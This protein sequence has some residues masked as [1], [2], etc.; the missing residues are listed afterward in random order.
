ML[1]AGCSSSTGNGS[2]TPTGT[3]AS[4]GSPQPALT[5]DLQAP[6]PSRARERG[7]HPVVYVTFDDGPSSTNTPPLLTILRR[8]HAHATFFVI[9]RFARANPSLVKAEIAAGH[10]VGGHSWSHPH[11]T[12]LSSSKVRAQLVSTRDLL[13]GLG[14]TARCFRP[15]FG[16]TD[17]SV[18]TIASDLDHR[19]KGLDPREY[20]RRSA[21]RSRRFG[22]RRRHRLSRRGWLRVGAIARSRRRV[23]DGRLQARLRGRRASLLTRPLGTSPNPHISL[24]LTTQRCR[25]LM[26]STRTG[27]LH[28]SAI[29]SAAAHADKS[30]TSTPQLATRCR[31]CWN[32]RRNWCGVL[33][34]ARSGECRDDNADLR[35]GRCGRTA[36]ASGPSHAGA[37]QRPA[38]GSQ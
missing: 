11:L 5:V 37:P 30:G 18:R 13:R 22:T 12:E 3:P 20:R 38:A 24:A 8:H 33:L 7:G 35:T 26:L 36:G 27:D 29:A 31:R 23:P 4:S 34:R 32:R 1:T 25:L 10:A 9:G 19:V 28:E 14:S 16:E 2:S 21:T 6:V 15:P 17:S